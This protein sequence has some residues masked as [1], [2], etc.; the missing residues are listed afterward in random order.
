MEWV[1]ITGKTIEEAKELAL[2]Q[3]GVDID[4]AEFE[5]LD[6][7]QCRPLRPGSRRSARAWP[8][9]SGRPALQGRR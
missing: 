9:P 4:E 1:E 5:I 6:E 7:P 8:G 3:L 2:D